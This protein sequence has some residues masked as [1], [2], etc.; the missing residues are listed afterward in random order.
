LIVMH[1][2]SQEENEV[3]VL[4]GGYFRNSHQSP[5]M[6]HTAL[7]QLARWGSGLTL[8]QVPARIREDAVN[9]VLSTLAAVYS[10]WDSDLGG[11][12]ERA[13]SSPASG[14]G[15][16]LPTGVAAPESHAAF[17]M[18]AW[19]M[20]LDFDDVMLGGHTGHSSVLVPWAMATG[21][22][23]ADLVLAQIVANEI[24][25]RI[26]MVCAMGSVRGQMATHLHL[27]AASAARAKLENLSEDEFE[28]AISFA[29]SY[30]AQALYPAFLG[31]DAKVLCAALPIRTG[32]EAIDA[33]HAGLS[34]AADVLDDQRGFFKTLSR[35][36]VRDFL[37]GLGE[38]WHT[39]TNSFKIYPVCGY[40]C[41]AL[42]AT[43]DLVHAHDI[44]PDEVVSVDVWTSLFAVAMDAHS[45]PYLDGAKSRIATLTF[46]TPFV[47]ASAILAR[48]FTPAQLKRSWI[49]DERVWQLAARI[50][51]RHDVNL[52][53]ESMRGDIPIGAALH[54]T[55]RWHGAAFGWRLA[56][57][58][59]GR[60]RRWLQPDTIRLVAGMA[61][62][63]GKNEN[64][65]LAASTKPIGARVEIRLADGRVLRRSVSIPRGFAGSGANVRELMRTKFIAA[66]G[67]VIGHQ[68]AFEAE[69]LI[70][71]LHV[72]SSAELVYLINLLGD[73]K[74]LYVESQKYQ[75]G[76][77]NQVLF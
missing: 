1:L 39:Q 26:N 27:I 29:L 8:E 74:R 31:S 41:S 45:A 62:A 12:I 7:R 67:P 68:R 40:L 56:T 71:D 54:R 14:P 17:L 43:L 64:L 35:V 57:I 58:A 18:S 13:F 77:V 15:R 55:K 20:A 48:E 10:G 36:P 53:L 16:I 60:V 23:G 70:E 25:A 19:S 42:D 76:T 32:M 2:L 6:K 61:A 3:Q 51:S 49:E 38:R 5:F 69:R 9:Q 47:I 72:L 63:A 34:P 37:D 33:V 46:S 50:R 22:T 52:T 75:L 21:R 66:V 73:K 44:T 11:P 65:D 28:D 4:R 24:A 30:P 59:F